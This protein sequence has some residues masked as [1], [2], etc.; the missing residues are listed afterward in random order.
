VQVNTSSCSSPVLTAPRHVCATCKLYNSTKESIFQIE[1]DVSHFPRIAETGRSVRVSYCKFDALTLLVHHKGFPHTLL[2]T[3]TLIIGWCRHCQG[4]ARA[5]LW[6]SSSTGTSPTRL[7][8]SPSQLGQ[9][10]TTSGGMPGCLHRSSGITSLKLG[11]LTI[12]ACSKTSRCVCFGGLVPCCL[13]ELY[14]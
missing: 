2:L 1:C 7:C 6:Q 10:I 11:A 13:G 5:A 4:Q 9:T 14:H 8:S 3:T 12:L